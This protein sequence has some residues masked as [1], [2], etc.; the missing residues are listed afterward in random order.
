MKR[1]IFMFLVI[2]ASMIFF[3]C[4]E[5]NSTAPE[6]SQGDQVT[7]TLAKTKTLF[8][9]SA[10]IVCDPT[11][12]IIPGTIKPLPDGK[13]L[14]EGI[15]VRYDMVSENEFVTGE[16]VW[17]VNKRISADK[18]KTKL[19][20]EIELL[21]DVDGKSGKWDITFHGWRKGKSIIIKAVGEGKEGSVKGLVGKWTYYMT[22]P[23]NIC[24]RKFHLI[25]GYISK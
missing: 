12:P 8:S 16:C 7:T 17:Y 13:L 25:E 5:N 10:K 6:L 24:L 20:G 19:W 11:H 15:K 23:S 2:G 22:I 14:V 1:S 18:S 3:C 4:S 21:V 9:G